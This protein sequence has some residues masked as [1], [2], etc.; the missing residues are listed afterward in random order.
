MKVPA[1]YEW[2]ETVEEG[3]LLA[4]GPRI[5][6][7]FRHVA[8]LVSKVLHG[9]KPADLPV[10]QP[11]TFTLAINTRTALAIGLQVPEQMLLRADVVVD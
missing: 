4:Y 2:P 8:V 5:S 11:T 1:L 3:G 6:L 7:C 9:A 10:E